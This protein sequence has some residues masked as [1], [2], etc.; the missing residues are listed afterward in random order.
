MVRSISLMADGQQLLVSTASGA[1]YQA[2]SVDLSYTV[3]SVSTTSPI[4]CLAFPPCSY[5]APPLAC[6]FASGSV[7]GEVRVWDLT[8]YAC[9]SALRV[10]KSGSVLSLVLVDSEHILSGWQDGS[11]RCSD[12]NGKQLWV[13]A[14]AHRDGVTS[15]AVHVDAGLQYFATGGGDG[16]IRVWKYPNR[17]LITQYTEHRKGVAKVLVDNK[18]PHIVHSVGGDCSVL[19]YDL[20]AGKRI[21][22][23]II[24]AGMMASMTQRKDGENELITC[25]SMGRLLYWDI[26]IRDPVIAVQD[27][28]RSI[29]RAIEVSPSGRFVAYAGDDQILK[30]LDSRTQQIISLGQSHSATIL[31]LAWTP[32]EKQILSGGED[33]CL[34]VWNFFIGGEP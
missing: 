6:F 3:H 28:T 13:L 21:I 7:S 34:S 10:P 26:D 29:I 12:S 31:S 30:V 17:E 15:V 11:I 4:S 2:N 19:S 5:P 33:S 18:S 9:I 27:P 8:D 22:C 25:D 20:K 14:S 32:D 16:A 24:N 1:L 23:H